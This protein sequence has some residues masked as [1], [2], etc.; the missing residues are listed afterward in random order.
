GEFLAEHNFS[1][2]FTDY[3]ILPMGAAIW[4]SSPASIREYPAA[5]FLHFFQNHGLLNLFK[6]PQW[7]TIV[8]GSKE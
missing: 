3:Y 4:S 1:Q 7:E 5:S 2:A 8:G 6:R